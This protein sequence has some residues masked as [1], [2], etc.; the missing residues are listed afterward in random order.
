MKPVFERRN[1]RQEVFAIGLLFPDAVLNSRS[2]GREGQ[3]SNRTLSAITLGTPAT[4]TIQM[5]LVGVAVSSF[6]AFVEPSWTP[7][8]AAHLAWKVP[9]GWT[10]W[11]VTTI[12]LHR[13]T[14][15]S[16]S[17]IDVLGVGQ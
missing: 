13:S 15:E 11:R 12:F 10:K 9:K 3:S 7:P 5:Q 1:P 4:V 16:H 2:R 17:V 14:R 6:T 8:Y